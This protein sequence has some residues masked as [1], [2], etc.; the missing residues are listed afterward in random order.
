MIQSRGRALEKRSEEGLALRDAVGPPVQLQRITR[1]RILTVRWRIQHHA[2]YAFCRQDSAYLRVQRLRQSGF[3]A[4]L[5]DEE[6][7]LGRP[8]P[9]SQHER[10]PSVRKRL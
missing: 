7:R 10:A 5:K 8:L 6:Q 9:A 2:E 3:D 4:A 1:C